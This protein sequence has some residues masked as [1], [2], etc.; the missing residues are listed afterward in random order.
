MAA[1]VRLMIEAKQLKN[2]DV[3]QGWKHGCKCFQIHAR[4]LVMKLP[5]SSTSLA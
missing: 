3:Q 5:N 1:P 4:R 2:T